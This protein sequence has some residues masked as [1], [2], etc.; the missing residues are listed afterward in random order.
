MSY[1][2][3]DNIFDSSTYLGQNHQ[4]KRR[5]HDVILSSKYIY[6]HLMMLIIFLQD[7]NET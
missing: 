4:K 3:I 6:D 7:K 2:I 1:P 5:I